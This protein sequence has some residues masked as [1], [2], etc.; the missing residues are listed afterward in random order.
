MNYLN[1]MEVKKNTNKYTDWLDILPTIRKGLNKYRER[2]ITKLK[3]LQNESFFDT[4][5]KPEYEIGDIVHYKLLKP[6]TIRGHA[7]NDTKF[8]EGDRRFSIDT[9]KIESILYYPDKPWYRYTLEG[10]PH[11]SFSANELIPNTNTRQED[12][13]YIVK[14]IIGHKT[15]NKIKYYLVWWKGYL[16]RD[17]TYEKASDLERDGLQDYINTYE[18]KTKKKR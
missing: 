3:K 13:T 11:I 16:K 5:K 14:E 12:T 4:S 15:S 1:S 6:V 18:N 8:R 9:K 10:L 17:A 7:I 2:N